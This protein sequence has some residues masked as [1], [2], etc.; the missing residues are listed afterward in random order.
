MNIP[1]ITINGKRLTNIQSKIIKVAFHKHI[2]CPNSQR[3][4]QFDIEKSGVENKR[5]AEI[6]LAMER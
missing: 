5:L 6:K 3:F 2:G 4:Y 1:E